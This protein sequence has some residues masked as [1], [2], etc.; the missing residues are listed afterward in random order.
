[1]EQHQSLQCLL[2]LSHEAGSRGS[3]RSLQVYVPS[4]AHTRHHVCSV[5]SDARF[6]LCCWIS[7]VPCIVSK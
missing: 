2:V 1:M 4:K 5:Y 6:V 3:L 7:R